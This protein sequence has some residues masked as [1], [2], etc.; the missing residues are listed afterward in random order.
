MNVFD[1]KA[2]RLQRDRS[3]QLPNFEDAQYVKDEVHVQNN[4]SLS[5]SHRHVGQEMRIPYSSNDEF[6]KKTT[7]VNY[8]LHMK[9]ISHVYCSLLCETVGGN[10]AVKCR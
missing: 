4:F 5:L 7:T 1:R 9:S 10:K 6:L 2:K 3:T 8:Q